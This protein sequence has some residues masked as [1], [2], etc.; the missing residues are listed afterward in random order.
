VFGQRMTT[1]ATRQQA[2]VVTLLLFGAWA[3]RAGSESSLP[4]DYRP[5]DTQALCP[6]LA[7]DFELCSEDTWSGNCAD[8]VVAAGRLG[9]IYRSELRA[10]P[11]W[12]AGLQDT[13]WWG[14][15]TA[16]LAELG[17]LLERI[18]TPQARA[19]LAQEPY[20]SLGKPRSRP[21]EASAAEEQDCLAPSTQAQRDA[22]AARRLARAR[23]E[24]ERV[25][26]A[27]R[28]RVAP[29]LRPELVEAE[30]GWEKDLVLECAGSGYVR[31]ECL[32]QAY[33]ERAQSIASMHPECAAPH[34]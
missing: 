28:D 12:I 1:R 16:P 9:E 34:S 5:P 30:T 20:R 26:A 8:F 10:H 21:P 4:P 15:G 19:V 27:C 7:E 33:Q 13:I 32:A 24:H 11:S 14:C 6:A 18:D 17:S 2:W 31:D 29:A 23:A 22:C 25:F 3:S